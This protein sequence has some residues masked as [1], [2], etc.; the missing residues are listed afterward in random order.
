MVLFACEKPLTDVPDDVI[1][2]WF[3]TLPELPLPAGRADGVMWFSNYLED[4]D[5]LRSRTFDEVEANEFAGWQARLKRSLGGREV[6]QASVSF[7][8]IGN[9]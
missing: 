1:E 9:K 5:P 8:R 6:F 4:K 7:A 3:K 2:L